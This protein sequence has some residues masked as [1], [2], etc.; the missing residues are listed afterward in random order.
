MY[1]SQLSFKDKDKL[2]GVLL[3]KVLP[4]HPFAAEALHRRPLVFRMNYK[5]RVTDLAF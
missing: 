1:D 5:K 4:L 2:S 3:A